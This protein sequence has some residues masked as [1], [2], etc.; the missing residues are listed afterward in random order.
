MEKLVCRQ[1]QAE[2]DCSSIAQGSA[3]IDSKQRQVSLPDLSNIDGAQVVQAFR[4]GV[5][6]TR[7]GKVEFEGTRVGNP[8]ASQEDGFT[9]RSGSR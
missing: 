3:L 4:T 2:F 6:E 1:S 9:A 7:T 5:C 8:F